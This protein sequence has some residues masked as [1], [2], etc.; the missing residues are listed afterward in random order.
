MVLGECI[1]I[2]LMILVKATYSKVHDSSYT[3]Y[4]FITAMLN[5]NHIL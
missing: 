2:Y 4:Q 5:P 3:F 1:Y